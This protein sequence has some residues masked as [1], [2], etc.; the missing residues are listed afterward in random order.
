MEY[1]HQVA[2]WYF[3]QIDAL[4]L[5]LFVFIGMTIESSF[6]PFPSEIIMPPA[7]HGAGTISRLILLISLGT[8]G[9]L[10]GAWI[11]YAIGYFLGRPFLLK[12]GKF[13]FINEDKLKKMD[14][15]WEK[16]GEG[17]TFI[18]RLIPGVRQIISIPAG[19]GKMNFFRF[20]LYTSL[21]AGIWVSILGY[22]GWYLRDW[23]IEDFQDRLKGEI[24]PYILAG[25]VLFVVVYVFSKRRAEKSSSA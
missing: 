16:Y 4:G 8:L 10:V 24:L 21:G 20:S 11:N 2:T 17:G 13:I 22:C 14:D 1:I 9:S 18:C 3:T 12:Y 6:F 25:I 7:G 15:F 23:S 19:M 5:E